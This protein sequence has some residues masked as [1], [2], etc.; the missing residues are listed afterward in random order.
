METALTLR[1]AALG[2]ALLL[3]ACQ[4]SPLQEKES[5]ETLTFQC[6]I[7]QESDVSKVS[8]TDAG[9]SRWEVGDAIL[10]HGEGSSNRK[11]VTLSAGD[12][13]ADGRTATVTVSSL[14]PYDRSADGVTSTYYA[15]YPAS[16]VKNINLYWYSTFQETNHL[17]LAGYNQGDKILFYNCCGVISFKVKGDFDSYIFSGNGGETLGYGTY[18]VK[19]VDQNGSASLN[20]EH[21]LKDPLSVLSGPVVTDGSTVNYIGLPNGADFTGGFTLK[22]KKGDTIVKVAETA[23]AVNVARGKILPLGDISARLQNASEGDNHHSGI[24]TANATDLGADGTA[25]CYI[26]NQAG[27]YKYKAVKGNSSSSVG[28]IASVEVLWETWCTGDAVTKGSVVSAADFQDNYIYFQTGGHAGN[29]LIAARNSAGTILWSWH[30]WVPETPVQTD[31]YKLSAALVMDR[32]LGALTTAPSGTDGRCFGL[33][34][35]WGRKDPFPGMKGISSSSVAS[36]SGTSTTVVN[37][38]VSTQEAIA[39]PTVL[40]AMQNIDWNATADDELWGKTSGTKTL[41]DPCPPGYKVPRRSDAGGLFA[42]LQTITGWQLFQSEGYLKV[43]SPATSFPLA[44]Y[45][46]DYITAPGSYTRV[47]Q[48]LMFWSADGSSAKAYGQD[49]RSDASPMTSSAKSEPKARGGSV[50]CVSEEVAPFVNEE[51]MPVQG[52]Y[53]RT[54]FSA[55]QVVELSG[56]CYSKD[57][58]FMWAVGDEGVLY[59]ITFDM[60]VTTQMTKEATSGTDMKGITIDPKTADLYVCTEPYKVKKIAAPNYNTIS[61]LFTVPEAENFGNSGLEGIT[62]YKDNVLYVGAQTGATLWAYKL[63][64]TKLWKKSLGAIAP[65]CEEVGDLYYDPDTDLLWVSDS[66]AR[67]LF[68]FDGAVTTLKAIYDTSPI[69]NPESVLVDHDRSCVYVGDDGSTSKIYKYSFTG[70]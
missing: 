10:I 24:D 9:K 11:V 66:E 25:N 54:V 48:R 41:Y 12:I 33:F 52:S 18:E 46:D 1:A 14:T 28:N 61:N 30:V 42:D 21:D 62:Y 58:D 29:A 17:L 57:K 44:G 3:G 60:K 55:D 7:A 31:T 47:G 15:A 65:G 67:K 63:D 19:L 26:V 68:V 39:T 36:V 51:G 16:A 50:R 20:Y 56:L 5:C 45:I 6:V 22:F 70:L 69:G 13:S 27:T 37:S 49:F 43:G 53:T 59:K 40:Y 8:V 23:T 2:A 35:Q 38:A 64:G 4:S 34:Y 32:N